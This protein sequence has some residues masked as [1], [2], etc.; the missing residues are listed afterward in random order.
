MKHIV[1]SIQPNKLPFI[2]QG[3]YCPD[4]EVVDPATVRV[5]PL[6]GNFDK[7]VMIGPEIISKASSKNKNDVAV[8]L[9]KMYRHHLKDPS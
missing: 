6:W 2:F 8:R 9:T 7:A 1:R 3:E 5:F 4:S